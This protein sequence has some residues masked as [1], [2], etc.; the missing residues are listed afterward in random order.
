VA[1][2]EAE[3]ISEDTPPAPPAGIKQPVPVFVNR[4]LGHR[5]RCAGCR[6]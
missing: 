3:S 1:K 2:G 5:P 4:D 6:N